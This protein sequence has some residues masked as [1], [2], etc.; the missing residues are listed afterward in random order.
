MNAGQELSP[1]QPGKLELTTVT[2]DPGSFRDTEGAGLG[3]HSPAIQESCSL[4]SKKGTETNIPPG[5]C[6]TQDI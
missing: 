4:S 3:E 6:P 5:F 2:P 1:S